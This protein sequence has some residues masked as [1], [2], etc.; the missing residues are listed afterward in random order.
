[1]RKQVELANIFVGG[2][3]FGIVAPDTWYNIYVWLVLPGYGDTLSLSFYRK[4]DDPHDPQW[5]A[6]AYDLRAEADLDHIPQYGTT[7]EKT[8]AQAITLPHPLTL[9]ALVELLSTVK[10]TAQAASTT[11]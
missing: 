8:Y 9:A 10:A 1:M 7:N 3:E 2:W 5:M 6:D 11:L 4:E